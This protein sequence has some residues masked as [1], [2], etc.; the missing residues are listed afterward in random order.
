MAVPLLIFEIPKLKKLHINRIALITGSLLPDIID[1]PFLFLGLG[2]GRFFSHSLIFILGAFLV[3]FLISKG[4][5]EISY[6]FLIGMIFHLVLD[7]PYIPLLF[8]FIFYEY[9]ILEDPLAVF[10]KRLFTNPIVIST[11]ISGIIILI[12]IIVHNKLY[13]VKD[14]FK[15]LNST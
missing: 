5:K 7:L 9:E 6:P 11:E 2:S 3:L 1:K 14:F 13:N 4:N 8:P 12:F 15:Y 10:I